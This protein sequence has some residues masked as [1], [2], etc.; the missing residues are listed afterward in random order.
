MGDLRDLLLMLNDALVDRVIKSPEYQPGQPF[1][2][3]QFEAGV[4]VILGQR[5]LFNASS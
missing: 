3:E 2:V 1:K 5:N 4:D